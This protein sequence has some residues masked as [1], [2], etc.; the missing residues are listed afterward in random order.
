MVAQGMEGYLVDWAIV[1][2]I[3]LDQLAQ[4][5]VPYFDG[6]VDC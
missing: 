3:V 5:S 4:P 1:G 6:S 2:V